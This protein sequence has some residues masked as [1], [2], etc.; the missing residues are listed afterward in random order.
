MFQLVQFDIQSPATREERSG[1][2]DAKMT[3]KTMMAAEP[4]I[5]RDKWFTVFFLT[6]SGELNF[7]SVTCSKLVIK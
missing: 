3:A 6:L 5:L 4:Q 7:N 2:D 1:G